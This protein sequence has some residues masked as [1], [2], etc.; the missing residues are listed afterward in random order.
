[1]PKRTVGRDA[2]MRIRGL[3]VRERITSGFVTTADQFV[4]SLLFVREF[5]EVMAPDSDKTLEILNIANKT[6]FIFMFLSFDL[7]KKYKLHIV[8]VVYFFKKPIFFKINTPYGESCQNAFKNPEAF[9]SFK[10]GSGK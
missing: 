8:N 4:S 1:V 2:V 10:N 3:I 6:F 7:I 5:F 9:F